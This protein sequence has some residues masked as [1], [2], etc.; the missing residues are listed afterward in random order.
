MKSEPNMFTLNVKNYFLGYTENIE[1]LD[2]EKSCQVEYLA[3]VT[4]KLEASQQQ[5]L[6]SQFE[7][8][9]KTV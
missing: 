9:K 2:Y 1:I 7:L 6:K 3:H 8:L 4:L 5:S